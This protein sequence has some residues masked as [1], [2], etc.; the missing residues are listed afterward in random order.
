MKSTGLMQRLRFSRLLVLTGM[1]AACGLIDLSTAAAQDQSAPPVEEKATLSAEEILARTGKK[2]GGE[3]IAKNFRSFWAD[4]E[5]WYNHPDRGEVYFQV[6][7][8]FQF[9]D[10]LWTEKRHETQDNPTWEVFDGTDGWFIDAEGNVKV[11]TDSPSSYKTD[12]ENLEQDVRIT[13]ELFNN[14]FIAN[15]RGD[16]NDLERLSDKPLSKGKTP[17]YVVAGKRSTRIRDEKER[18]AYLKIFVDPDEFIVK[19]VEMIDLQNRDQSRRFL[20]EAF[21]RTRQGV[22]IPTRVLLQ[23]EDEKEP[24]MKIYINCERGKDQKIYPTIKFNITVKPELF[25][26]PEP[27]EEE[28]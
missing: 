18:T 19:A 6:K 22:L 11:Y 21:L 15:L 24:E 14:F 8:I 16:L 26:I 13:R 12:M 5:T 1:F 3:E 27:D 20:F 9:P 2:Q 28:E 23:Q 10:M 25:Q 17:M 4:F 7:R